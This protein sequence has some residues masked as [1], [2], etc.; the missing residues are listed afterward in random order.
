MVVVLD[1]N[2]FTVDCVSQQSC[3]YGFEG[4]IFVFTPEIKYD[5]VQRIFRISI[6]E[7]IDFII[8]D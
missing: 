1:T 2:H 8:A 4:L 7:G 5:P 3:E 6:K